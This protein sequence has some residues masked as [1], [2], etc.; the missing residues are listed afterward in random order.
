MAVIVCE[1]AAP[2]DGD[3]PARRFSAAPAPAGGSGALLREAV[4]F[5]PAS[6]RVWLENRRETGD[7]PAFGT[8]RVVVSGG[9]GLRSR[10]NFALVQRLAQALHGAAGASRAAVNAGWAPYARQ[11]GQSG[12]TVPARRV[13]RLRDLRRGSAPGRD[14]GCR[15]R[16]RDQQRSA[17][18]DLPAGGLRIVGD[19]PEVLRA[20]L[21]AL[22]QPAK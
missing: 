17:G 6:L 9:L 8:S 5:D 2:P 20:L 1:N 14:R 4:P 19:A 11:I 10:E 18:V 16:D 3:D 21:A 15:Y 12:K 22:A 7:G 13:Y